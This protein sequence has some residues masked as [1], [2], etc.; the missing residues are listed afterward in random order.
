VEAQLLTKTPTRWISGI[1]VRLESTVHTLTD[2]PLSESELDNIN[3]QIVGTG[4]FVC[5]FHGNIVIG[6][7]RK[8]TTKNQISKKK[9]K[10][11]HL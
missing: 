8:Y 2:E 5:L 11:H 10:K 1:V 9:Q 3:N 6:L 7:Q 4:F